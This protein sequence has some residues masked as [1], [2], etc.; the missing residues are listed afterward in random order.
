[1]SLLTG[2]IGFSDI[3]NYPHITEWAI[4]R[5][6]R[7]RRVRHMRHFRKPS[8]GALLLGEHTSLRLGLAGLGILT[9]LGLTVTVWRFYRNIR[10]LIAQIQEFV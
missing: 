5:A 9:T 8:F 1:M 2:D 3:H 10:R 7:N 6:P 4:C